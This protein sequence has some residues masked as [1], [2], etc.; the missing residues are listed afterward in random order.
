MRRSPSDRSTMQ[1]SRFWPGALNLLD[2]TWR[3]VSWSIPRI[4]RDRRHAV[5]VGC[6]WQRPTG[7]LIACPERVSG[8]VRAHFRR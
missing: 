3:N 1:E 4:S 8:Q 7:M 6:I 5:A 2:L